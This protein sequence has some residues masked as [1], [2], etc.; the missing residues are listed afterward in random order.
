MAVARSGYVGLAR[1]RIMATGTWPQ[2]LTPTLFG[3][4][5]VPQA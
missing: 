1:M 3:L 4:P 5:T 2:P